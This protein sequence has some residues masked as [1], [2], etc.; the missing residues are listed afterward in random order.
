MAIYAVDLFCGVGGLTHGIQQAGINVVAGIDIDSTS[1]Y[2]YEK[3]NNAVFINKNV[4]SLSGNEVKSLYP[5]G[6]LKLLMGC[7]PCQPFSSYTNRYKEKREKDSKWGLLYSFERI[8]SEVQPE[9][10]S[11]ENVPEIVKETIFSDFVKSLENNDYIVKWEIVFCP[12]YG[13]PQNRKRL[14]LLASKLGSLSL[15]PPLY[16]KENY[17]TVRDVIGD[18][19]KIKAGER[20]KNDPLH[21]SSKLKDINIKRII[22]SKPGGTWRDWDESLILEC[23]KKKS[24]KTYPSVYGRM[25]WDKPAPTIT[26]QFYG[27]GNGRFGHPEQNRALS[28]R[29]GALIQTFPLNY[30][31]V[32]P[33]E[34]INMRKVGTH[35]GN[36][37]PVKLG[38]I[39][40][41]SI[42]LHLKEYEDNGGK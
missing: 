31:F 17:L 9:I 29:E 6:S 32:D 4:E 13:V 7:A 26:T 39:I 21:V 1:E 36:A 30:D 15:L 20:H 35:I 8:I 10:V 16:S 2:A 14:V 33:K 40:G 11:M 3:N 38:E 27:Y 19:P 41:E 18:L 28:L 34:N 22:Q 25:E 37:V 42:K 23:H 12:D 24:G 5:E